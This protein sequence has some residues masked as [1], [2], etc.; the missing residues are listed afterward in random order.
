MELRPAGKACQ[1][2]L[3][4]VICVALW[5]EAARGD[6]TSFASQPAAATVE[7]HAGWMARLPDAHLLSQLSLPGTHDTCA[8]HDGFSFGFAKCQSWALG[9][10]LNAGIRFLDIRCRHLGDRFAIYHGIID[11][12]MGFDEVRDVCRDFL[13]QHPTECIVMSVK[14][15]SSAKGNTRSFAETFAA[16]T[17]D[18]GKLWHISTKMPKLQEVR[19]RVV[20]L[21]R[22]GTLG[23]LKWSATQLQDQYSTPVENKSKLIRGHFKKASDGQQDQWF[24]NYCSGT[25]PGR[26]LTPRQYAAKTNAVAL[27]YVKQLKRKERVRLGTVVMDF[28]GEELIEQV[29]ATN[30]APHQPN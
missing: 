22:V 9:D 19:G 20:L 29:I 2:L 16:I 26:L 7:K 28:P 27:D 15:E 3:L 21:D 23:G 17:Q 10:Q 30:F 6:S 4:W 13:K 24:I 11:Q 5:G 1:L 8:L 18:D 12:R 14:E 25:L